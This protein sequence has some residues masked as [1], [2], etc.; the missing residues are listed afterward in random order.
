MP[1]TSPPPPTSP[2]PCSHSQGES[3][4]ECG[5]ASTWDVWL[6]DWQQQLTATVGEVSNEL[7]DIMGMLSPGRVAALAPPVSTAIEATSPIEEEPSIS[8]PE[9]VTEHPLQPVSVMT[10]EESVT[11]NA[12]VAHFTDE[13]ISSA[14]VG[15]EQMRL[16]ALKARL[17]ERLRD[18][19][20]TVESE[21]DKEVP[22]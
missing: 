14:V 12:A 7:N 4:S 11:P 19:L 1:E 22:Q 13:Q 17:A 5:T 3:R 15:D 2:A 8:A 9:F 21:S 16:S 20:E 18:Q 6:N 10:P